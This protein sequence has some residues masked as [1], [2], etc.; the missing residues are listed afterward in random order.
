MHVDADPLDY[1]KYSAK[2]LIDYAA[3]QKYDVLAITCHDYVF[4]V[5]EIQEYAASKGI[6]M[7]QGAEKT[8]Q[9]KH[10]LLYNITQEELESVETFDDLRKLRKRKNILVL[11]PH[12]YYPMQ[13]CLK[14]LL[15][16]N[17]DCFDGIE[18]SHA[19]IK[20][21]NPNKKAEI[22]AQKY[23]KA[24]VGMSDTHHLFQFGTTY[25]LVDAEKTQD[26]VI[27]AI[28][29]GKVKHVSP[30]LSPRKAA[31]VFWWVSSSLMRKF[32][33]GNSRK[34]HL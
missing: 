8:L 29:C 25:S 10:V 13:F 17:I 18:Y 23:G 33:F 16:K 3:E 2:E 20:G 11:A 26:A 6:I 22:V 4:P 12:P 34:Q 27:A 19:H 7:I 1:I 9:G 14:D 30:P 21:I 28:K 15:E 24:L 5:S 32:F 31:K